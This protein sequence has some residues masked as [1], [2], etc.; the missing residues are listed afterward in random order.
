VFYEATGLIKEIRAYYTSPAVKDTAELPRVG[1][2]HM[3]ELVAFDY[4]GRGHHLNWKQ[5]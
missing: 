4:A 5:T 1:S 3:G 2:T